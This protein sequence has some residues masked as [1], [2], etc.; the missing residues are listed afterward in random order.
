[1]LIFISSNICGCT[2]YITRCILSLVSIYTCCRLYSF[3]LDG[4]CYLN[5]T[6]PSTAIRKLIALI[7][8]L[9]DI[10]RILR[11][12]K[13]TEDVSPISWHFL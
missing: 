11:T 12:D 6:I 7:C 4:K 2:L 9:T 10:Q 1:M 5:L 3:I 8:S 13:Y